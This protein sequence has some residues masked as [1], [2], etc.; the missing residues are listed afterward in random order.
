M[1][2]HTGTFDVDVRSVIEL[3]GLL[4]KPRSHIKLVHLI[5]AI[6]ITS[7]KLS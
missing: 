1:M 5:V 2:H 3:L 7:I 4:L 6:R